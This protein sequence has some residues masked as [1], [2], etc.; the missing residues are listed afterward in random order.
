MPRWV[1]EACHGL[2]VLSAVPEHLRVSDAAW[3]SAWCLVDA[4][5]DVEELWSLPAPFVSPIEG[6]GLQIEWDL[7]QH[8]LEIEFVNAETLVVLWEH[9]FREVHTAEFPVTHVERVIGLLKWL[10]RGKEDAE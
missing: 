4:L 2:T 7:G 5:K 1:D 8:H 9:Q 3:V 6:G 10:L